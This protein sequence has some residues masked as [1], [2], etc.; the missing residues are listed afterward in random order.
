MATLPLDQLAAVLGGLS[1]SFSFVMP[2][3]RRCEVVTLAH[4]RAA[5]QLHQVASWLWRGSDLAVVLTRTPY[6]AEDAK[7]L[8]EYYEALPL[9]RRLDK[10]L[11]FFAG[12]ELLQSRGLIDREEFP[13]LRRAIDFYAVAL[14]VACIMPRRVFYNIHR[15]FW[16]LERSRA[17]REVRE[18]PT[19][20]LLSTEAGA[21]LCL[22]RRGWSSAQRGQR[23]GWH[24]LGSSA[25]GLGC[26]GRWR[27]CL[28][29]GC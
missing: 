21:C 9:D 27:C 12:V 8:W 24:G 13:K 23:W 29:A 18:P 10:L 25:A 15:V 2:E 3:R 4:S 11:L 14:G 5:E 6:L 20:L 26:P 28:A 17:W 22:E 19:P 7:D 1:S 16:A